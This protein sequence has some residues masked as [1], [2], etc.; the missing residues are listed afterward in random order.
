MVTID[1]F[2]ALALSYPDT[3]ELLHFDIPSFRYKNR[4]FATYWEKDNRA[5]LKLSPIDQSVFCAY[6]KAVFLP[7]NGAWGRQGATFVELK[8][9]RKDM[10]RDALKL[11]YDGVVQKTKGG[12]K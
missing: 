6:P 11:A 3:E 12:K 2:R 5:M 10:F 7:V 1:E 8:K 9:V 4:I